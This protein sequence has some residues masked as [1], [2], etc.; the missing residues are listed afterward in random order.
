M[1]KILTIFL[2]V[3]NRSLDVTTRAGTKYLEGEKRENIVAN[4]VV[5]RGQAGLVRQV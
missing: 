1:S 4:R 2:T 5:T 3:F